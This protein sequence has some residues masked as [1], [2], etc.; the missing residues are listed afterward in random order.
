MIIMVSQGLTVYQALLHLYPSKSLR[1]KPAYLISSAMQF[2]FTT[3]SFRDL[4]R[5]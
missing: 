3:V 1:R 4:D 2:D 5:R